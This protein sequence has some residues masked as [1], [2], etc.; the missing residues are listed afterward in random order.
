MIAFK[1]M[2]EF[3]ILRLLEYS[4]KKS[5]TAIA[6]KHRHPQQQQQYQQK[7]DPIQMAE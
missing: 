5:L 6:E 7:A 3:V 2:N 4:I 1:T